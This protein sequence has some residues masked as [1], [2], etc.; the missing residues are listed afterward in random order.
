MP[1]IC[2]VASHGV[3]TS[4]LFGH[5]FFY[6]FKFMYHVGDD[7]LGCVRVGVSPS[8]VETTLDVGGLKVGKHIGKMFGKSFLGAVGLEKS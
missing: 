3:L 1:N 5:Q 7:T 4:E 2:M 8:A 6:R